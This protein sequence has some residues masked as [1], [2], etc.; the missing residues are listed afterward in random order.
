MCEM[1]GEDDKGGWG[2]PPFEVVGGRDEAGLGGTDGGGGPWRP[3]NARWDL[4]VTFIFSSSS[5]RGNC[6]A[7]S[8]P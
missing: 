7:R 1:S 4:R 3:R 2:C 6:G 5:P 8:N